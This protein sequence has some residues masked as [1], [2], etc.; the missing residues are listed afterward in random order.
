MTYGK[1]SVT[2]DHRSTLEQI[3]KQLSKLGQESKVS[4]IL[5]LIISPAHGQVGPEA[6]GMLAFVGLV[7]LVGII[8]GIGKAIHWA[9]SKKNE[10]PK[11]TDIKA[12]TA[13]ARD[14]CDQLSNKTPAELAT[15]SALT[16]TY[17]QMQKAYGEICKEA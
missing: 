4:S 5:N 6:L 1:K 16:E 10:P 11:P 7:I 15:Q 17:A 2:V 9:F 13:A 14:L 3:K 8:I 12:L